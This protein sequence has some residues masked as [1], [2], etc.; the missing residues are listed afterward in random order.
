MQT[1]VPQQWNDALK[2]FLISSLLAFIFNY[3]LH[4]SQQK[5]IFLFDWQGMDLWFANIFFCDG[6]QMEVGEWGIYKACF[7]QM[8]VSV[9][10]FFL[11]LPPFLRVF[12]LKLA[13][14]HSPGTFQP[15][16]K[17]VEMTLEVF[18]HFSDDKLILWCHRRG[19]WERPH[20]G[21]SWW[22]FIILIFK[23]HLHIMGLTFLHQ[24][25]FQI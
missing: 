20:S 15:V 2:C 13:A 23:N 19:R 6:S 1:Y 10:F 5:C 14:W 17:N 7:Y 22:S 4:N 16:E 3:F 9:T 21:P 18:V 11:L 24:L 8:H 25:P 12:V